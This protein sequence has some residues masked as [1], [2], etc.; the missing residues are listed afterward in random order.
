MSFFRTMSTGRK[1]AHRHH[2]ALCQQEGQIGSLDVIICYLEPM[3][4]MYT[5]ETV[6]QVLLAIDHMSSGTANEKSEFKLTITPVYKGRDAFSR[7]ASSILC[8][9]ACASSDVGSMDTSSKFGKASSDWYVLTC[10]WLCAF[11]ITCCYL[12]V[13]RVVVL[14]DMPR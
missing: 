9:A 7:S 5:R 13:Y 8:R 11:I 6:V 4:R 3:K 2:S 1:H 10:F 12:V 14:R